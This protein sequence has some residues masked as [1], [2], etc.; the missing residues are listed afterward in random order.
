M[1]GKYNQTNIKLRLGNHA[2]KFE[3]DQ[4][5]K[6]SRSY[7]VNKV[8]DFNELNANDII[9]TIKRY[10]KGYKANGAITNYNS[11]NMQDVDMLIVLKP[12]FEQLGFDYVTLNEGRLG[13]YLTMKKDDMDVKITPKG[14]DVEVSCFNQFVDD[15]E[16]FATTDIQGI[17]DFVQDMLASSKE[18]QTEQDEQQAFSDDSDK[19]Y[20]YLDK[21]WSGDGDKEDLKPILD[22]YRH[23]PRLSEQVAQWERQHENWLQ[24]NNM[25]ES[26]YTQSDIDYLQSIINGTLQ[27]TLAN[28]D[29]I[30]LELERIAEKGEIDEKLLDDAMMT[31]TNFVSSIKVG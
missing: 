6:N 30:L 23:D 13:F 1:R 12:Q 14:E 31:Y 5:D 17:V 10:I 27:L 4:Y 28:K 24:E 26:N 19:L 15:K 29:E 7:P 18:Y 21:G 8:I 3:I 11:V 20:E 2:L 25:N 22:K 9:T 16:V